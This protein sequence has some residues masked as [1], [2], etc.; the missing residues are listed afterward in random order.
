MLFNSIPFVVF[1]LVV[2][3]LYVILTHRYQNALLLVASYFFYGSWDWRFLGLM[4]LS[5]TMD[6]G[7]GLLL[8]RVQDE[9]RRRLILIT[10]V[11]VNL[12]ILF[13]FKYFNFFAVS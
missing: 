4:L 5:T 1:F 9:A 8:G 3:G 11:S 13:V 2:Y 10:S 12:G 6:Y 7:F